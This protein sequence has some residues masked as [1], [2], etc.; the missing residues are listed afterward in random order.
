MAN[1]T[2]I[3]TERN[4]SSISINTAEGV[5]EYRW[6]DKIA[7]FCAQ[8]KAGDQVEFA[9]TDMIMTYITK[10]KPAQPK[11]FASNEIGVVVNRNDSVIIIDVSGALGEYTASDNVKTFCSKLKVDDQVEFAY[12][13]ERIITYIK[14][15]GNNSN[16]QPANNIDMPKT[17]VSQSGTGTIGTGDVPSSNIPTTGT[18]SEPPMKTLIPK[19]QQPVSSNLPLTN[20]GQDIRAQ[21]YTTDAVNL[22]CCVMK[23]YP[24]ATIEEQAMIA[25]QYAQIIIEL[26]EIFNCDG[27]NQVA[28][29]YRE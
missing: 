4:S 12:N 19:S 7:T 25:K 1:K 6:I 13:K 10:I 14:K 28:G 29:V 5:G 8:L 3:V 15:I 24:N 22:M 23:H 27:H 17:T 2:G 9:D 20:T 16:N 21:H 18:P 26:G 11:A